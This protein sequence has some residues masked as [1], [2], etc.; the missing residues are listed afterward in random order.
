M[1]GSY[2]SWVIDPESFPKALEVTAIDAQWS[3]HGIAAQDL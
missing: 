1:A 2:H 3:Y